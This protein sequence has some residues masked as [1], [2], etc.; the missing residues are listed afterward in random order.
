MQVCSTP[1]G[2]GPTHVPR[3]MCCI[4]INGHVLKS[5]GA[6]GTLL[7]PALPQVTKANEG[8]AAGAQQ[9]RSHKAAAAA[10]PRDHVAVLLVRHLG[11]CVRGG[12]H[13]QGGQARDHVAVLMVRHL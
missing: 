7:M 6:H 2:E 1:W 8:D 11:V 3:C 10:V 4:Y 5:A 13:R 12:R 9:G